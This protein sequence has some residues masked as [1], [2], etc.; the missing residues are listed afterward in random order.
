MCESLSSHMCFIINFSW[1]I[2]SNSTPPHYLVMWYMY[3]LFMMGILAKQWIS[4]AQLTATQL[5]TICRACGLKR[6]CC[7]FFRSTFVVRKKNKK[8]IWLP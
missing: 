8:E 3:I 1:T 7:M 5:L 6:C 2:T 4:E